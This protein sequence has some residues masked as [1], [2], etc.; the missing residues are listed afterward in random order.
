[1]KKIFRLSLLT[2]LLINLYFSSAWAQ[3]MPDDPDLPPELVSIELN[4][5][6]SKEL[7]LVLDKWKLIIID[8]E[9]QI[10]RLKTSD[11]VCVENLEDRRQL[12]CS[13]YDDLRSREV[14]KYNKNADPLFKTL[15]KQIALE[16]D[17]ES[18]TCMLTAEKVACSLSVNIY[19][20]SMGFLVQQPKPKPK[21]REI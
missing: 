13:L 18:E 21:K 6:D 9:T 10:K 20:C 7:F 14:Y 1:M 4:E 5:A 3:V 17:D 15:V 11:V 8:R 12:G 16:C 2:F 19:S